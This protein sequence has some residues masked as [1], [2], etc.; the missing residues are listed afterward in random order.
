MNDAMIVKSDED[1]GTASTE[2]KVTDSGSFE[3]LGRRLTARIARLEARSR[4][5]FRWRIVLFLLFIAILPL[6]VSVAL[7]LPL[8]AA[9]AVA[10]FTVAS[11]H[12]RIDH[13]VARCRAWMK[14]KRE[15]Q[16]RR[17]LDWEHL[18]PPAAGLFP[19]G[20]PFAGDIDLE[21]PASLHRLLDLSVSHRGSNLLASW[22]GTTLPD[23]DTITRRQKLV[24]ALS[25]LR[26]FREHLRL[27]YDL[28][29]AEKLDG[30]AFVAWLRGARIPS[31]VR[32]LLP[33]MSVLAAINVAL[34]LLWG[35]DQLPPWF[36]LGVFVY[37]VLY[38]VFSHVREAFLAA[39]VQLDIELGRLKTVFRFLENYSYGEKD[40]L[41][42]LVAP[43]L[44]PRDKPS[45]H[46]R[47]ILRDV[48]AA[49]LSMNPVMMVVLN[50]PLPWDFLFAARL[51]RKRQA[52]E[53]RL[54][55]WLDTL[56]QL[57]AL[58]SLANFAD[59]HPAYH[60]P[61]I[62]A[63]SVSPRT[64]D[65]VPPRSHGEDP[66][67]ADNEAPLFAAEELG[68]PLI[69]HTNRVSNDFAIDRQGRVF[70]ITGSN[71]SGKSTFL[72]TVGINIAL[73]F[74]GGPVAARAMHTQLFRLSTCINISD[75]LREGVSY[76]YAEVRRLRELLEA[77]KIVEA[78][79]LLF[80]IDEIFKGTNNIE[81]HVGAASYVE[82]LAG[83]RGCGIVSTHD[84]D[85][86]QLADR[87]PDVVNLHFR[88][89]I[90]D[91]RMVFD[92]HLRT[93][94]CPTTNAL[95]IMRL[96]GLPVPEQH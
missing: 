21:G 82:A 72:R 24:R 79:P 68:H 55:G 60:F 74:A 76:F 38:F 87:L 18:P 61:E 36:L 13:G 81:R 4:R 39:A 63:T 65:T 56:Q 83:G 88:E 85:L 95:T 84:I 7:R 31:S 92:Y 9:T 29:S 91:D 70:L 28:V 59:L 43:F 64:A 23:I 58:Q 30:D 14:L 3:A 90:V 51:E 93:G 69:P 49:G 27:A 96:E 5:C 10:F 42:G 16:A 37:G 6:P 86:T 71:M 53:E 35:Y 34:F 67:T 78:P 40:E 22:L 80:L 11:V 52:L 48:V 47:R 77:T 57:E 1:T 46:I 8:L 66:A 89:H 15:Q 26:H 25:P 94:P 12:R 75:S 33:V 2:G 41:R 45:Q 62:R 50:L 44:D 20:H 54:P 19:A 17:D 32:V 73:A